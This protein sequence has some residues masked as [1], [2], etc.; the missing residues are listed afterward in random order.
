LRQKILST[1]NRRKKVREA[2]TQANK[3]LSWD[4]LPKWQLREIISVNRS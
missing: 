4:R 2:Q 1:N 3:K